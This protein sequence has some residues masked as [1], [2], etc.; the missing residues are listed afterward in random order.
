MPGRVKKVRK[1]GFTLIEL[2]I[3]LVI[4]GLVMAIIVP[5]FYGRRERSHIGAFV[6]QLNSLVQ[7]AWRNAL[8]T[9]QLQRITF[10]FVDDKIVLMQ[11]A[12]KNATG[13]KDEFK[14]VRG[15]L[16]PTEVAVPEHYSFANFYIEGRDEMAL[17][18]RKDAYFFIMPDGTAQQVVINIK[19]QGEDVEARRVG[20]VLNPFTAQFEWHD[21]FEKP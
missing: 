6:T 15:L 12:G 4:M 16:T 3:V 17:G 18:K 21:E 19:V 5:T 10:N 2:V 20:L 11:A 1:S 13:D 7:G 8:T 9:H 14:P